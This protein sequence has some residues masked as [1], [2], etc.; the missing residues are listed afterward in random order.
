MRIT[1]TSKDG[2]IRSTRSQIAA[3]L[4]C[5]FA[6][7]GQA[8]AVTTE[9]LARKLEA[10]EQQNAA[11]QARLNKL[12]AS[13]A[14][15]SSQ[16]KQQAQVVEPAQQWSQSAATASSADESAASTTVGSYG[17]IGY[18]RPSKAPENANVSVG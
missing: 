8:S 6:A 10:L 3:G 17:E 4:L 5:A 9:E 12:E 14:P 13:Q 1:M 11:L 18:T 7:A 15:Q 16:V 2:R